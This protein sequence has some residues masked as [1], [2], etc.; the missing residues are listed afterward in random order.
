LSLIDPVNKIASDA[1]G[2]KKT[3]RSRRWGLD[4]KIDGGETTSPSSSA[5]T[6]PMAASQ[7]PRRPVKE[8]KAPTPKGEGARNSGGLIEL[9]GKGELWRH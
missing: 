5:L 3:E 4:L 9:G 7:V 6:I 1:R 8:R 2:D